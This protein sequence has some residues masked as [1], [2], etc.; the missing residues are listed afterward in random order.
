MG[1]TGYLE[2]GQI[3]DK[4]L[5]YA[6][7]FVFML[8]EEDYHPLPSLYYEVTLN[9][10][11]EIPFVFGLSSMAEWHLPPQQVTCTVHSKQLELPSGNMLQLEPSDLNPLTVG[12][13]LLLPHGAVFFTVNGRPLKSLFPFQTEELGQDP[14][15]PFLNSFQ[16]EL[17]LGDTY[18]MFGKANERENRLSMAAL[19]HD[20]Q[21]TRTN[22]V[23][24][25]TRY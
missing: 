9:S 11:T 15:V 7:D 18:F 19:L 25:E 23:K 1:E 4:L 10:A 21:D 13:G 22:R 14:L 3:R 6:R 17:N 16:I 12:C 2:D 8:D 5:G 24:K 20:Y